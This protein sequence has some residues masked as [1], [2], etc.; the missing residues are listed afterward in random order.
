MKQK[1]D[2]TGMTC[3][4]CS[5]HVDK[6]VR[7]IRGVGE[8]NVNLLKNSMVVEYDE[9]L[10]NDDAIIA[11]VVSGGYGAAVAGQKTVATKKTDEEEAKVKGRL[12]ISFASLIPLMYISMGHM[13]GL[14]F[15]SVFD[16]IE[17]S[18]AFA[19]TQFLLTIPIIF[20]NRKYFSGG[21]KSLINRSPNM[22]TLIAI[23]SGASLVYGIFAIYMI[24]YGL[25]EQNHQLA[26]KYMMNLYFEGAAMILTLITLGKYFEARAKG[27][28]TEAIEKLMDLA[29]KTATVRKD[30]IEIT[31]P[32][33]EVSKGDIVI[34]KS[35]EAIALDG[36][37]IKGSAAIDESAITGESIPVEKTENDKVIGGTIISSGYIEFEVEKTGEDTTLSQIIR[38]VEEASSSK[39]PIAKL[40]D[41]VSLIFVP[42]VITI[43]VVTLIIW[44]ALGYGIAHA[45]N[46]A[47]SVLVISCPCALGLATP[48]AIMVG[49]GSGARMGILIKSAAALEMAHSIDTVVLDKTGTI[50]HG[51]PSV[52]DIIPIGISEN[53]FLQIAHS[54]EKQSS[55]PLAVAIC[56]K[57]ISA[58]VLCVTNYEEIPGRG[59]K[60][61]I[62]DKEILAGNFT[63]MRENGIEA[64]EDTMLSE[65]G[66]TTIYFAYDERFIGVIALR[67]TVKETSAKAIEELKKL[68]TQVVMLTGDNKKTARAIQKELGIDTVIA[69]VLPQDK[70]EKIRTLQNEGKKV[71][72]VGD[73]INDAP[74]LTRADVGIAI[75]NGTD[76]AIESADIVLMRGDLTSVADAI[77]LSCAVT[78]NIKQNLFWAFFYNILGIPVAAG[79]LYVAFGISLSPMI[80]AAAMSCSSVFVVTN[81][82]RLRFF[83]IKQSKKSNKNKEDIKMVIKIKGMMCTHCTGRVSDVLNAIDGVSAEVNLDNGG[84]AVIALS[85]DVDEAVLTS[86]ITNAGYEVVS[87]EK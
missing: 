78:K 62:S 5:A 37:I 84:Q 73:G 61:I 6:S 49:T 48:T 83:G 52:T 60:G 50:T 51:K 66:K 38:L 67:D 35:G 54:I 74:A 64:E 18:L 32:A 45:L 44:L 34:V 39:A 68:K 42:A 7:M 17:N 79:A 75:G 28:T 76:I 2:I 87:V 19:F 10:T 3:S 63:M 46:M 80:A 9:S 41:K 30:G 14:P 11:A 71:A 55:H 1:Y 13:W 65:H 33:E 24:G 77:R 4:A 82:L 69:E 16:K 22:D 47:I 59:V 57:E 85:K 26:H 15:L 36:V 86:A 12:I 56:E 40:A 25:G 53:E 81:A 58:D 23:G 43:A 29:P 27:K 8:V 72:M 20:V 31:V 70:E 21:F